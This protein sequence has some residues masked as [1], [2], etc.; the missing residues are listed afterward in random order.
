ML[1]SKLYNQLSA[2]LILVF[3]EASALLLRRITSLYLRFTVDYAVRQIARLA[4]NTS[5]G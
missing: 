4:I 1:V 2:I 5:S 3:L